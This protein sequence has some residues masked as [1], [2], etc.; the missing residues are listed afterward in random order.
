[1]VSGLLV[2]TEQIPPYYP[3]GDNPLK[4][5]EKAKRPYYENSNVRKY[6]IR[7]GSRCSQSRNALK[8]DVNE[9]N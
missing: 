2:V 9:I 7:G 4:D 8:L 1:V 3:P 6:G 5:T